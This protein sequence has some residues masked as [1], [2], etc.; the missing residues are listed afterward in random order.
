MKYT[1]VAPDAFQKLQL[2]AGILL[3][4]FNPSTGAFNS[5]DIFAA[6]GGGVSFTATPEL[7]DFGEDIDNVP[8]NTK[9]LAQIDYYTVEMSGTAKTADTATAKKLIG[10][11]DITSGKIVP[12][13]DLVSTDFTDVWWVGDYGE[14]HEGTGAGFMAIHLMDALS[15]GGFSMQT[16][17]KGKADFSFTFRGFYDL[18]NVDTVPFEIYISEGSATSGGA[19]H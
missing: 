10:A 2:N 4:D 11:A 16:N 19:T 18:E 6:T 13:A 1:Q 3:T 12:R 8:S 7:I 5:A 14:H 17:D 9:Q 15:T